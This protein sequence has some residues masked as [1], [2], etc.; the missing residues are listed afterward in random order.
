MEAVKVTGFPDAEFKVA[1]MTHEDLLS[2]VALERECKLNSRGVDGYQRMLLNPNAVLLVAIKDDG[3]RYI[4]GMFSAVVVVDEL[5][6]DNLAV[7][8]RYRRRGIGQMLLMSAL[9][10]ARQL[11]ARSATL[12]VRSGNLPARALYEMQ[13]FEIVGFRQKYYATPPDDAI[14][15]SHEIR[16]E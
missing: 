7:S 2:V 16:D 6:I 9:S 3:N 1:P 4:G 8:E 10:R 14:L 15:L 13:G 11:G 5:Q 12:D